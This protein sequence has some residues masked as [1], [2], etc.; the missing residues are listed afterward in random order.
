MLIKASKTVGMVVVLVFLFAA[1]S[2]AQG[3]TGNSGSHETMTPEMA[4]ENNPIIRHGV[5][6]LKAIDQN[7]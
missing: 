4:K 5:I 6:D 7:K 1:L 3:I 2:F